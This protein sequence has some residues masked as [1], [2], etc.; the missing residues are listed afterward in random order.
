MKDLSVTGETLLHDPASGSIVFEHLGS[1]E[2]NDV[3]VESGPRMNGA[4]LESDLID[5]L[6]IYMSLVY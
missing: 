2:I 4:L 6:I 5:E 1:L 3:L